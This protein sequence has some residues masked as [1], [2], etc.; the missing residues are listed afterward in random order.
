VCSEKGPRSVERY[1][2]SVPPIFRRAATLRSLFPTDEARN[3]VVDRESVVATTPAVEIEDL[4]NT[5]RRHVLI[6]VS[7][8]PAISHDL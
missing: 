7:V 5:D 8:G 6:N 4:F 2:L 1:F 3:Y